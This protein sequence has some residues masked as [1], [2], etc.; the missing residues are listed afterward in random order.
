MG[1][2][3]ILQDIP[4]T[5]QIRLGPGLTTHDGTVV[6]NRAGTLQQHSKTGQLWLHGKQK[7]CGIQCN[8]A[9]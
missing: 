4:D 7:R 9:L 8:G 6:C 3:D 2:G 1:P 5:G